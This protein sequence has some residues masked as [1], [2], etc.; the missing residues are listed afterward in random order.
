MKKELKY[1]G[2]TVLIVFI[3]F[4]LL[5]FNNDIGITKSNIEKD[6]R[7]SHKIVNDW[8]VAKSTTNSMSAMLFYDENLDDYKFSIYVNIRGLSFQYLNYYKMD[9]KLKWRTVCGPLVLTP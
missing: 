3:I 1:I 9:P 6:A 7:I 2:I 4:V 8:R 5:Y